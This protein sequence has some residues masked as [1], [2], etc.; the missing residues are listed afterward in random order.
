M[1]YLGLVNHPH[2]F[3]MKKN[4]LYSVLLLAV[5]AC[6]Q[7]DVKPATAPSAASQSAHEVAETKNVNCG[8][9]QSVSSYMLRWGFTG[10]NTNGSSYFYQRTTYGI[11]NY[12]AA[13]YQPLRVD[14]RWDAPL[15]FGPRS[16]DYLRLYLHLP[17]GTNAYMGQFNPS[18]GDRMTTINI[19]GVAISNDLYVRYDDAAVGEYYVYAEYGISGSTY[20]G[21]A[22]SSS[23]SNTP[24]ACAKVLYE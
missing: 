24:L 13:S 11:Q 5:G 10:A 15:C 23:T 14:V 7:A 17:D 20:I 6:Q 9:P 19:P 12:A 16:A 21:A 22:G 4:L 18:A 2:L 1:H 3:H 8:D